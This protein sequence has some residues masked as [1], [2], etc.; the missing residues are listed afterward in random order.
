MNVIKYKKM[1]GGLYKLVLSNGKEMKVYEDVILKYDLL[2]KKDIDAATII[3][4]QEANKEY[5]AYYM[6]LNSLRRRAK[7]VK[8]CHDYLE[9]KEYTDEVID[10]A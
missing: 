3:E 7:T 9:K 6:L 1:K 5:E 10:K 8:E 2:F 4:V